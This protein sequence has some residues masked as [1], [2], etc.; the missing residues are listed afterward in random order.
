VRRTELT[1]AVLHLVESGDSSP[2]H[3]WLTSTP[4]RPTK[5]LRLP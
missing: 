3:E 1:S 4:I 2:L 5:P